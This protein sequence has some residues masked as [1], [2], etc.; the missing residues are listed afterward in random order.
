MIKNLKWVDN[1]LDEAVLCIVDS[2]IE[3]ETKKPP[4]EEYGRNCIEPTNHKHAQ[5]I[6][7]LIFLHRFGN[8]EE[9]F[10]SETLFTAAIDILESANLI[11]ISAPINKGTTFEDEDENDFFNLNDAF[12][13]NK[14]DNTRVIHCIGYQYFIRSLANLQKKR[15]EINE[16]LH[17]KVVKE[18][19][20]KPI[21]TVTFV[22]REIKING[23]LLSCP[24]YKSKND[25]AFQYIYKHPGVEIMR[26]ETFVI[27]KRFTS[28][29][30]ELNFTGIIRKIFFPV[31]SKDSILFRDKVYK[32]DLGDNYKKFKQKDLEKL[33]KKIKA[34]KTSK[35]RRKKT[36]KRK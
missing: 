22:G 16:K 19:M 28:I 6:T 4:T 34:R 29:L 32:K 14:N 5:Q 30:E 27:E 7:N 10:I 12:P 11:R 36:R 35:I 1:N 26:G 18:K 3:K 33:I 9:F 23:V 2:M 25:I 24:Q 31:S 15:N 20:E 21:F 17:G 8:R 13:L